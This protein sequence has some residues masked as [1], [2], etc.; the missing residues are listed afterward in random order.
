MNESQKMIIDVEEI[1]SMNSRSRN[2]RFHK[3]VY[4]KGVNIYKK[5]SA[6]IHPGITVL[7]GCNGSGKTTLMRI[8]REKLERN[9]IP[10]I[11]YNNLSDGDTNSMQEALMSGN[12]KFLIE[13]SL[14]S[15][16]E[17]I[18]LNLRKVINQIVH[19]IKNGTLKKSSSVA[20][21]E[22]LRRASGIS[23]TDESDNVP[24]ELW[25][26]ID[27]ADSGLSIDNIIDLKFVLN[28]AILDNRT[29][30]T[31]YII[32]SCNEY[33]MCD[34]EQCFDVQKM[35]YVSIKS[36]SKFK[37]V[38]LDSRKYKDSLYSR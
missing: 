9:K 8:I 24:D 30:T 12:M 13:S 17:R 6:T 26:L 37:K 22:A 28:Q 38:I 5:G 36:Y 23:D 34:G 3:D 33:E 15:E 19:F 18:V 7:V 10:L 11:Y 20:L 27:A 35:K 14:S 29:G 31:F 21:M 25:I 4:D 1:D 2:F 32:V 16:G